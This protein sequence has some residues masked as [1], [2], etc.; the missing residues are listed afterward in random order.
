MSAKTLNYTSITNNNNNFGPQKCEKDCEI[1]RLKQMI[2]DLAKSNDEREKKIYDLNK[3][4]QRFKRIQDLVLTAQ[5][6]SGR[7]KCNFYCSFS[8]SF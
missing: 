5:N 2:E 6:G 1:D 8:Y 4:V 3:Q 7:S